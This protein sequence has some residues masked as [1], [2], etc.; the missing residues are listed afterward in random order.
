[1]MAL[2]AAACQAQDAVVKALRSQM[3]GFRQNILESAEKVSA[4]DYSFKPAP[5]VMSFHQLLAH[6]TDANYSLCSPLKNEANPNPGAT[7]KKAPGKDVIPALKASFDYCDGALAAMN[8]AKLAGAIKRG[9]AE[10][11]LAYYALHL[12]DHTA[13]HYGNMITYMRLKG[14]VPPET[15]RRNQAAAKK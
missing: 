10:R 11:P 6:L 8:D 4:A 14:I 1:M 13:L 2:C 9:N 3:D 12:L 5:E 15:E 7:E